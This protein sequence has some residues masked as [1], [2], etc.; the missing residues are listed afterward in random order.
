MAREAGS[1]GGSRTGAANLSRTGGGDVAA[2]HEVL[3][4]NGATA[5]VAGARILSGEG[6]VVHGGDV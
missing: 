3:D 6:D 5:V 4:R 2:V 1:G